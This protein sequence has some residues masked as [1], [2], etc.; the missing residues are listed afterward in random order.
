MEHCVR[1][2][3]AIFPE[4]YVLRM[5]QDKLQAEGE[6]KRLRMKEIR[7]RNKEIQELK[8]KRQALSAKKE[9]LKQQ[10]FEAYQDY[11]CG[12]TEN[13]QSDSSALRAMEK[14]LEDINEDIRK[15]EAVKDRIKG[16]IDNGDTDESVVLS[17]EMIEKYIDKIVVYDE[18]HMEI[19]WIETAGTAAVGQGNLAMI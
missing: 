5:I 19:K 15:K 9:K 12:R 17:K 11:A 1:K 10:S 3:N 16:G 18:Q 8:E 2:I 7:K 13:F 4:Q 6:P 14:E